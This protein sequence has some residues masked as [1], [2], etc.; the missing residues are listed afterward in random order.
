M[1]DTQDR[2]DAMRHLPPESWCRWKCDEPQEIERWGA[3]LRLAASK[4]F[5]DADRDLVDRLPLMLRL[6]AR[7]APFLLRRQASQVPAE[8]GHGR[9]RAP[10]RD[11]S[12]RP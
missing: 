3:N 2:H 9:G 7:F 8:P 1:V 5:L 12:S 10:P 6:T 4:T 11:N